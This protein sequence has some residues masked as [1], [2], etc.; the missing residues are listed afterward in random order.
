MVVHIAL[1]PTVHAATAPVNE[2]V[3]SAPVIEYVDYAPVIVTGMV[4]S[5]DTQC[6]AKPE[7]YADWKFVERPNLLIFFFFEALSSIS[8]GES[9][10]EQISDKIY[11]HRYSAAC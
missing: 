9:L 2:Y 11:M 10:I 6:T 5:Q 4:H 8:E 7:T 3:A 1:A